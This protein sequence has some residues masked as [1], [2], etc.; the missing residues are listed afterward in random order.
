M[1]GLSVITNRCKGPGDDF[2]SP[3]HEEVLTSIKSAEPH[4][5]ALVKTVVGNIDADA[6]EEPIAAAYFREHPLKPEDRAAALAAGGAG[7]GGCCTGGSCCGGS[8]STA[9]S[10]AAHATVA[11]LVAA[12]AYLLMR[13]R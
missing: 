5:Q 12:A 11:G 4:V 1:L 6:F 10:I 8:W 9:H 2:P 3:T 13:K 7:G